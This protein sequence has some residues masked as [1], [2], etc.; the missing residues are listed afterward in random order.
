MGE[1]YSELTCSRQTSFNTIPTPC[2]LRIITRHTIAFYC[3]PRKLKIV[4]KKEEKKEMKSEEKKCF[5]FVSLFFQ[6]SFDDTVTKNPIL[7]N[8]WKEIRRFLKW[9]AKKIP[10]VLCKF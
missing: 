1:I 4:Q 2:T 10:I 7:L 5:I 3:E 6:E 9:K 8:M